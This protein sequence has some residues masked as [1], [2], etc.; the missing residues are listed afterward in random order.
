M[1]AAM[2]QQEQQKPKAGPASG[3]LPIARDATHRVDPRHVP[4]SPADTSAHLGDVD[5][6]QEAPTGR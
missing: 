5:A 4:T 2:S 1:H 6:R 3:G